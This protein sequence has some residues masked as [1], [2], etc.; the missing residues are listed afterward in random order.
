MRVKK[1]EGGGSSVG[2]L[3][4]AGIEDESSLKVPAV[5]SWVPDIDPLPHRIATASM[6]DVF[7]VGSQLLI[8]R[9]V[10]SVPATGNALTECKSTERIIRIQIPARLAAFRE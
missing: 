4:I 8:L 2:M 7:S 3:L 9:G 5:T 10:I 1:T 6:T